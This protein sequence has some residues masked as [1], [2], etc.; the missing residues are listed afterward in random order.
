MDLRL[1]NVEPHLPT[2][3]AITIAFDEISASYN[4]SHK[5]KNTLRVIKRQSNN[6]I[7]EYFE[8]IFPEIIT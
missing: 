7:S 2:R 8:K 5:C 4:A 6:L 3:V 1:A